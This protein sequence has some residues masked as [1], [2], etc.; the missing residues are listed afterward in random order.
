MIKL[1]QFVP[2]GPIDVE[3]Q[4]WFR[5][6]L[7]TDYVRTHGMNHYT[8]MPVSENAVNNAWQLTSD[9]QLDDS[10]KVHVTHM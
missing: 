8:Y 10:G 1:S 7:C 3:N 4:N 9:H 2:E 6:W 5:S